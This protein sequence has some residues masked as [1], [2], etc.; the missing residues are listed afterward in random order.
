[1]KHDLIKRYGMKLTSVGK[2]NEIWKC[3]DYVMIWNKMSGLI[4]I[5]PESD[6]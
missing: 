4:K 3:D 1:M 6:E 2:Y 5:K